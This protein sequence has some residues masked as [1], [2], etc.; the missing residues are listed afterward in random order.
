MATT[1]TNN[2]TGLGSH[3]HRPVF[4]QHVHAINKDIYFLIESTIA[5]MNVP[6]TKS[7]TT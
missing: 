2:H 4:P 3:E 7:N 1:A 6:T 5:N